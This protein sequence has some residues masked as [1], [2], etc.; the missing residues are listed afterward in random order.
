[1]MWRFAVF[2]D[3]EQGGVAAM[4]QQGNRRAAA[5]DRV[6]KQVGSDLLSGGE[7]DRALDYV[8]QFAHISRPGIREQWA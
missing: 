4:F 7:N 3:V 8:F 2:D 5:Y 1:M 6:G